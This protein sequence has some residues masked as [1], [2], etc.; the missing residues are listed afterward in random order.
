MFNGTASERRDSRAENPGACSSS[1][2]GRL[3]FKGRRDREPRP[4]WPRGACALRA[5][6]RRRAR[7]CSCAVDRAT[8]AR[9]AP[10]SDDAPAGPRAKTGSLSTLAAENESHVW[11]CLISANYVKK[12][13]WRNPGVAC[14]RARVDER[15]AALSEGSRAERWSA[16]ARDRDR[17]RERDRRRRRPQ[18]PQLARRRRGVR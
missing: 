18:R 14:E 12:T 8:R 6:A 2:E 7:P 9:W 1:A 10:C 11:Q 4:R 5:S 15:R 17:R 13:K 3:R 16:G